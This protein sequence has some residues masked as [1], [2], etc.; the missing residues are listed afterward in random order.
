MNISKISILSAAV[1]SLAACGEHTHSFD[2]SKWEKDVNNHWHQCECG[3]KSN[4][5]PHIDDN[6][7]GNCDVCDI[8][9]KV[10][11]ELTEQEWDLAFGSMLENAH[12]HL[13]QSND[14]RTTELDYQIDGSKEKVQTSQLIYYISKENGSYYK[15][16]SYSSGQAWMKNPTTEQLLSDQAKLASGKYKNFIYDSATE[17]YKC[18]SFSAIAS[19]RTIDLTNIVAKFSNRKLIQIEYIITFE[20][21]DVF[22]HRLTVDKYGQMKVELPEIG[23]LPKV[24]A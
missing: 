23:Q 8:A 11:H 24:S 3:E 6:N 1:L 15:I 22:N 18:D 13:T 10:S 14:V 7:D 5:A 2:N 9:M 12:F 16:E 4:I 17:T 19:G 20:K 21:T